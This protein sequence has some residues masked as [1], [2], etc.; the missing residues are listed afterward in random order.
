MVGFK[1]FTGGK[2]GFSLDNFSKV[3]TR[4]V[5]SRLIV[6]SDRPTA[7]KTPRLKMVKIGG[8]NDFELVVNT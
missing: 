4:M 3:V 8:V 2:D 6:T 5:L 1:L 7:K